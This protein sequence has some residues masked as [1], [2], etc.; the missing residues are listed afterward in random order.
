MPPTPR[1]LSR[2]YLPR[3]TV[4]SRAL[5]RTRMPSYAAS[6]PSLLVYAVITH[7]G[8]CTSHVQWMV[9]WPCPTGFARVVPMSASARDLGANLGTR[10]RERR[11]ALGWSQA[12]LA[13]AA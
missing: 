1:T 4:P 3:R 7:Y 12:E 10:I 11:E 8:T 6:T 9:A 2:R 5:A 13:E